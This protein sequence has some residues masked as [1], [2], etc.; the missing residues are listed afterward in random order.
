M[1]RAPPVFATRLRSNLHAIRARGLD[2]G[3]VYE[4]FDRLGASEHDWAGR[5]GEKLG[6]DCPHNERL[7]VRVL[8]VPEYDETG[9]ELGCSLYDLSHGIA[10][11]DVHPD[12]YAWEPAH[13]GGLFGDVGS[14]L[15]SELPSALL[16]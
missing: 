7:E 4:R 10:V 15:A 9:V 1:P 11:P 13:R 12:A 2:R 14:Q 6:R 3:V 16:G 8:G 5:M